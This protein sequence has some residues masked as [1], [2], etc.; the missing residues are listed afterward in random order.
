MLG[1]NTQVVIGDNSPTPSEQIGG[2]VEL[3]LWFDEC[4][5]IGLGGRFFAIDNGDIDYSEE[6]NGNRILASPFTQNGIPNSEVVGFPNTTPDGSV[7]RI[8]VQ[9]TSEIVG[10]DL[11]LRVIGMRDCRWGFDLIAGYQYSRINEGVTIRR[12]ILLTAGLNP[13]ATLNQT[14]IFDATNEFHGL[15]LGMKGNCCYDWWSIHW[16]AKVGIGN[17]EQSVNVNGSSI[18]TNA[19]GRGL[20]AN[21][22]NIGNH[23]R[24]QFAVVP[25][26]NARIEYQASKLVSVSLGYSILYWSNVVLP[27]EQINTNLDAPFSFVENDYFVHGISAGLHIGY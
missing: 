10:G 6:A 5:L 14:D 16:L 25:E 18:G 24:N 22:N 21:P 27:G 20:L 8:D 4:H 17:M 9:T 19:P 23:Q 13:G 12:D 3:G 7:G 15:V 11:Y 2:R 1:P 26:L